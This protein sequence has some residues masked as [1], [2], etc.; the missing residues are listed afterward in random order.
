M[1][2]AKKSKKQIII[3]L[4]N[5]IEWS[6]SASGQD[7]K[8]ITGDIFD[9]VGLYHAIENPSQHCDV[10]YARKI[11]QEMGHRVL[12][13]MC[14]HIYKDRYVKRKSRPESNQ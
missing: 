3:D 10:L 5:S 13:G 12:I 7:V 2:T 6:Q 14:F 9:S 11:I 1:K 4:F 8:M